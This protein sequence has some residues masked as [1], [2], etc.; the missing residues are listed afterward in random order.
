MSKPSPAMIVAVLALF[1]ALGGVGVAA[2]GGNFILGQSNTADKTT[3]L[4]APLAGGKALQV[5][6]TNTASGST[7]LGLSVASGHAP[8]TVNSSTKVANLN[9]DQL[10]NLDST[11]FLPKTGKAADADKLDNLDSTYFLPKT[12]KAAD[13]D[14][15]DGI[16]SSG[17]APAQNLTW[18]PAQLA[19]YGNY[20]WGNYGGGWST[21]AYAKDPFGIVHLKGLVKCVGAISCVAPDTTLFNLPV[22]YRPAEYSTFAT[23]SYNQLGRITVASDDGRVVMEVGS[24]VWVSLDGITFPAA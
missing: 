15:L 6:N 20:W 16:D 1:V 8:L 12:G 5:S 18:I 9:A 17:F 2:T 22:G 4:A 23:I 24:P 14:K 19:D 3:A 11:Y 13:A 21:A 7:A 10:D